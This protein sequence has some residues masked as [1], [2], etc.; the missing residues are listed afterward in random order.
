[1]IQPNEETPV[2]IEPVNLVRIYEWLSI[3]HENL[4]IELTNC[5]LV[6]FLGR[7]FDSIF[8]LY[9]LPYNPHLNSRSGTVSTTTARFGNST[10]RV[11]NSTSLTRPKF[12]LPSLPTDASNSSA[13]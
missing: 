1:M 12:E 7:E 2:D 13:R 8:D 4:L 9:D 5:I 11:G 10:R 3:T 6:D